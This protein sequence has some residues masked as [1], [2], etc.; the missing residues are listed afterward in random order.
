MAARLLKS[1]ASTLRNDQISSQLIEHR[2]AV[3]TRCC[4]G[5]QGLTDRAAG[6]RSMQSAASWLPA[7]GTR[8]DVL[9]A[10]PAIRLANRQ[11]HRGS[12]HSAAFQ[13]S[14]ARTWPARLSGSRPFSSGLSCQPISCRP[15]IDSSRPRTH[16]A[17]VAGSGGFYHGPRDAP[18][19]D[20]GARS[21]AVWTGRNPS[22][23]ER[24]VAIGLAP[25]PALCR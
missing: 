6:Q 21:F 9:P 23:D 15:T 24:C 20:F 4:R 22:E 3:Q 8:V 10:E 16:G 25:L 18:F 12:L 1:L 11:L 17:V 5:W 2:A 7:P 19:A 14:A 13:P